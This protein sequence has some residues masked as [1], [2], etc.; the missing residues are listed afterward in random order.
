MQ[1]GIF[2]K[3][4]SRSSL[5]GVLDAVAAHG[6]R[7]IQFNFSCLG[8][9]SLPDEIAPETATQVRQACAQRGIGIAAVSGTFNMIHPEAAQRRDGLRRLDVLAGA[10]AALGTSVITL[11]T[12]TRNPDNMWR[13]HPANGSAAAW[14]DLR[15]SM[16]AALAIA[17]RHDVTLAIE[18]EVTNVIDSAIKARR[19]LDEVDSPRLKVV[20]DAANLFHPGELERQDEILRAS[21]VVLAHDIVLAHAKD[22]IRD[23]EAG[24]RAAGTGVLNFPLYL[25]LLHRLGY[26]GPLILHGLAEEE[27]AGSVSFLLRELEQLGLHP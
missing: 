2:A 10:C 16:D 14:S 6:L 20:M 17:E 25:G 13:A 9:P 26:R 5:D 3:T 15:A 7:L 11:C 8:G 23:G 24:D 12:G 21:V 19:L 22:L 27:V 1:P 18:P 4:F